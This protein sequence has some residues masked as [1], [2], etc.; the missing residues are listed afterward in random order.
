[1]SDFVMCQILLNISNTV[2]IKLNIPKPSK[3]IQFIVLKHFIIFVC[4]PF[5]FGI[6]ESLTWQ[7]TENRHPSLAK[8]KDSRIQGIGTL[9]VHFCRD[10]SQLLFRV[11]TFLMPMSFSWKM[12]MHFSSPYSILSFFLIYFYVSDL[13]LWYSLP[14]CGFLL[15]SHHLTWFCAHFLLCFPVFV[16]DLTPGVILLMS[17]QGPYY[18]YSILYVPM[19][20]GLFSFLY[21]VFLVYYMLAKEILFSHLYFKISVTSFCLFWSQSLAKYLSQWLFSLKTNKKPVIEGDQP[22]FCYLISLWLWTIS[23]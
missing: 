20:L 1:M 8:A 15:I 12:V 22:M 23:F 17:G 9:S 19:T 21:T 4:I 11:M 5:L 6:A 7:S 18:I 13:D 3:S 14:L 16:L 10:L 2:N